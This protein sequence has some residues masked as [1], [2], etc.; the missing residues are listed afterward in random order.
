MTSAG[1]PLEPLDLIGPDNQQQ[2]AD[3]RP[4]RPERISLQTNAIGRDPERAGELQ[5]LLF[6]AGRERISVSG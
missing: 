6:A 3:L 1:R 2:V 4:D 5:G